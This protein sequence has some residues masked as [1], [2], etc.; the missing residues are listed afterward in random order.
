MSTEHNRKTVVE[1]YTQVFNDKDPHG[2]ADAHLGERYVQHNPT[3]PDGR[4]GF[5]TFAALLAE[6]APG[7]CLE[8][9]R[10]VAEGDYV[11]THSRLTLPGAPDR[12]VMDW[13]RLEDGKIV[14]HWD[15]IQEVPATSAN[16]NGMF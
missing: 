11:V 6:R 1:F 14:E 13:W 10:V 15:A 3:A 5:L 8:I 4:D 12:S 2:A 9:Q 16:D 7:L